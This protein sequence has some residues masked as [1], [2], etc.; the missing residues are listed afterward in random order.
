M[1][2]VS[3]QHKHQ[4]ELNSYWTTYTPPMV[5]FQISSLCDSIQNLL[6]LKVGTQGGETICWCHVQQL[7]CCYPPDG[8]TFFVSIQSFP[9]VVCPIHRFE[10]MALLG[11]SNF[12]L[13]CHSQSSLPVTVPLFFSG[14]QPCCMCTF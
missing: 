7:M 10:A 12:A 1:A 6:S 14:Y 3:K 9:C 11:K 13:R 2:T 4:T 5:K 8:A